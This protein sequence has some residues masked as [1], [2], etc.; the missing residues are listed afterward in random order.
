[1]DQTSWWTVLLARPERLLV[2][3]F[4]G[5]V[6]GGTVLLA[7]PQSAATGHSIGFMD[8]AF[9]ATSAGCVTGLI[10]LDTPLAFSPL[11][12]AF[13]L[14]LIQVG[15]LGIMTFSTA[16]MW[17]LGRRM[18]L[19][20][21]GVAASLISRRDRGRL[22]EATKQILLL[23][24]ASLVINP[25]RDFGNRFANQLLYENVHEEMPLGE[26]LVVTEVA[27]PKGLVGGSLE[28]L[29]LP[30]RFGVTV[31][32]IRESRSGKVVTPGP[33][34]VLDDGDVMVVVSQERAV[35]KMIERS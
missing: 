19:P 25:E 11:G 26:G 33:S 1:M 35:A 13:L 27:V 14:L 17:A 31:V 7:L 29:A 8:A 9:T 20:Y 28:Q 18:S 16:A 32:A 5:L 12:Q 2:G 21:E 3:T 6:L 15:G 30:R 10:V 24:G 22:F 23:T 34:S 4:A